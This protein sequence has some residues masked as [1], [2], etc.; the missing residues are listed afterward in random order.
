MVFNYHN[1]ITRVGIGQNK[2]FTLI[3]HF[4][5]LLEQFVSL[6]SK[7]LLMYTRRV[8]EYRGLHNY[9]HG[10]SFYYVC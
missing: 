5:F 3:L 9:Y 2:L 6:L 8:I 1:V 10:I 7:L 4:K